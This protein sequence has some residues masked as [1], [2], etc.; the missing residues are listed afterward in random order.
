MLTEESLLC[1]IGAV[2]Q[3]DILSAGQALG[4][5]PGPRRKQYIRPLL[6]AAVLTALLAATV[7]AAGLLGR[8]DRLAPMPPDASGEARQAEIPNGFRGTPTYQGSAQWWEFM[9]RWQLDHGREPVDYSLR[10]TQGDLDRYLVCSHYEAYD[11]RQAQALYEIAESHD[12]QLYREA[13]Y[14]GFE[15]EEFYGLT[16]VRP[17]LYRKNPKFQGGYVLEDGSF[18]A[19]VSLQVETRRLSFHL[20]RYYSGSIYPFGGA[21]KLRPYEETAYE[22]AGGYPVFLDVFENGEG[23]VTY[24]DPQ[25][26]TYITLRARLDPERPALETLR[27]TADAVDFEALC[28]RDTSR[29]LALLDRPTGAEKNPAAVNKLE[30]FQESP[31]FR[32]GKEFQAFYEENFYGRCFT[33]TY[34]LEGCGDID[35]ELTRL[36]EKYGLTC[37]R[38]KTRGNRISDRA[39][40]FSNGAWMAGARRAGYFHYIPKNALYTMQRNFLDIHA[41]RRIW[42]YE[43]EEGQ[44]LVLCTQGPIHSEFAGGYALLEQE[45]A[46]LLLEFYGSSPDYME[47]RV[48]AM[49]FTIFEPK[50]DEK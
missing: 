29:V 15:D 24:C 38:E 11:P 25:G 23:E 2:R 49:D 45:D 46:Y 20:Q 32:A 9:A 30:Q 43:T 8:A 16:G 3:E 31:V 17:F 33:G 12:L 39:S 14:F 18:A 37:A 34:G 50:E 19:E 44:T 4:Y 6:I 36:E 1:A 5:L 41:Y 10:F 28:H 47:Q 26:E 13:V 7:V 42:E 27:Q 40:V 22:T 21:G 35:R 48:E